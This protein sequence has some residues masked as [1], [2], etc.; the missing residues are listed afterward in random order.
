M[1]KTTSM[2]MQTFRVLFIFNSLANEFM[3]SKSK[4]PNSM[5]SKAGKTK[6][7]EQRK[8]LSSP[9]HVS[10]IGKNQATSLSNSST[11]VNHKANSESHKGRSFISKEID[12]NSSNKFSGKMFHQSTVDDS[13][14]NSKFYF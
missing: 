6:M 7:I 2:S 9:K 14:A 1:I 5:C 8:N 12:Q 3:R 13:L 4:G 10:K 11:P